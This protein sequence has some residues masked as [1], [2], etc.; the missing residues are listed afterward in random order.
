MSAGFSEE[1]VSSFDSESFVMVDVTQY[2]KE[3]HGRDGDIK[4]CTAN[5]GPS[6]HNV[7]LDIDASKR[8]RKALK[9]AEKFLES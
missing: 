5:G 6:P 1:V 4:V 7:W 2:T 9:R 3:V 8:L